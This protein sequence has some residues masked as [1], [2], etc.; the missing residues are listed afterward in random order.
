MELGGSITSRS[1]G[2]GVSTSG[3]LPR[4]SD[5]SIL[6]GGVAGGGL[7]ATDLRGVSSEEKGTSGII[8]P[9]SKGSL[10]LGVDAAKAPTRILSLSS[11]RGSSLKVNRGNDVIITAGNSLKVIGLFVNY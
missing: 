11:A 1:P 2:L 6:G 5:R 8:R 4:E 3:S 9:G 7:W 10:L